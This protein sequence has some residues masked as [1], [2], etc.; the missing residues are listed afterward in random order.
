MFNANGSMRKTTKSKSL[1]L[2][3][4][5]HVL[6]VPSAYASLVDMGFICS[7]AFPTSDDRDTMTHSGKDYLW[8]D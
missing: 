5:Q 3:S 8:C 1:Q 4:R 2:F 6:E 7:L